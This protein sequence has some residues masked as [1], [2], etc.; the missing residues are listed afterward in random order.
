MLLDGVSPVVLIGLFGLYIAL[1]VAALILLIYLLIRY[2]KKQAAK[3]AGN[4]K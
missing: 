1:P 4:E 3:E 2:R